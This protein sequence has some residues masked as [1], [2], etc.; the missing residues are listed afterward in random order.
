MDNQD[1]LLQALQKPSMDSAD[2]RF[3]TP[4]GSN[5]L[6]G[7]EIL[8]RYGVVTNLHRTPTRTCDSLLKSIV[9]RINTGCVD[10]VDSAARLRKGKLRFDL[11]LPARGMPFNV[12]TDIL[13]TWKADPTSPLN[14]FRQKKGCV[15][16]VEF[17]LLGSLPGAEDQRWHKD[18]TRGRA[19]LISFGVAL[20]DV[21]AQD[22]PLHVIPYGFSNRHK[23]KPFALSVAKGELFAWDG[24][25]RHR[26]SANRSQFSRPVLMFTLAFT[27]PVPNNADQSAH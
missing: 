11:K 1:Y 4:D 19:Q 21:M 13:R 14:Q 9:R 27:H 17:S 3:I 12:V 7:S 10:H 22:G 15:H 6:C 20:T 23:R 5:L 18:H 26:G 24:A 16:L 8:R 2:E 25:V